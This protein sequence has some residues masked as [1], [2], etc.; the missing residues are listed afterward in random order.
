V[1]PKARIG[2]QPGGLAAAGRFHQC[3]GDVAME[4]TGVRY[5]Q[6][7]AAGAVRLRRRP[8][9]GEE[10]AVRS[11]RRFA[12]GLHGGVAR[13]LPYEATKPAACRPQL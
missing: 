7:R 2:I 11:R 13:A 8:E 4:K 10:T 1:A 6:L 5:A 12:P 3:A 9:A